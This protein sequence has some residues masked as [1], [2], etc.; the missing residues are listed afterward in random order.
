MPRESAERPWTL[1]DAPALHGRTAIVTGAT[2]G[3]GFEVAL[4]LA[5]RGATTVL[6]GRDEAKGALALAAIRSRYPNASIR[7]AVLDLSSLASVAGFASRWTGRL[8]VLVNNAA[9]M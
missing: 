1:M 8:D 3:L 7:F 5:A 9:V 2:G 6:A 4:G